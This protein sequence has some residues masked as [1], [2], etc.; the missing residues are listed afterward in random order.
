MPWSFNEIEINGG[1]LA[2]I[3][4]TLPAGLTCIIGPRG[5]GKSTLAEALRYV[6]LGIPSSSR[7][8][9]DLIQANLGASSI[10]VASARTRV[11]PT[12]SVRRSYK[13]AP[14]VQTEDGRPVEGVDL[15]RGTFL[16]LDAYTALEIEAIAD[17]SLGPKRRALLDDL[18]PEQLREIHAGLA[19]RRRALEANADRLRLAKTRLSDLKERLEEAGDVRARL[20][21][22]P[23]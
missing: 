1:F 13:E 14:G 18:R 19:E 11:G 3:R 22:T 21:A 16:P 17:E 2:G 4:L 23:P 8:R 12:Y 15:D 9:Q 10:V 20:A 5:S 6:I 7:I